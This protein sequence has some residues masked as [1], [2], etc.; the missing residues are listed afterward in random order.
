MFFSVTKGIQSI[1]WAA[2]AVCWVLAISVSYIS[3]QYSTNWQL[4][5]HW[6]HPL[7]HVFSHQYLMLI[8]K[9]GSVIVQFSTN[10]WRKSHS[11]WHPPCKMGS[12]GRE[13]G[14]GVGGNQEGH[15]YSIMCLMK[16][17]SS[18]STEVILLPPG[19]F[20]HNIQL[21]W[22]HVTFSPL[23]AD[24]LWRHLREVDLSDVKV[25]A[26]C[27]YP[28][29]VTK[30]WLMSPS[31]PDTS[32]KYHQHS[33]ADGVITGGNLIIQHSADHIQFTGLKTLPLI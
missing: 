3:V 11:V 31:G 22:W 24:F 20:N 10:I 29:G 30:V 6:Q 27:R 13:G 12:E 8:C 19:G 7:T 21:D 5:V 16:L 14:A 33:A 25:W 15:S 17:C 9:Q 4:T 26:D 2:A 1:T 32:H 23:L 18:W 28:G